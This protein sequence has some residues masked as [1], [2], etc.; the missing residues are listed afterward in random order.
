MPDGVEYDLA[1]GLIPIIRS[2]GVPQIQSGQTSATF[3]AKDENDANRILGILRA[4]GIVP[5]VTGARRV[6]T[7]VPTG[8]LEFSIPGEAAWRSLGKTAI[9][10]ACVLFGNETVRLHVDKTVRQSVFSGNPPIDQFAGWDF[11]NPWPQKY[12]FRPHKGCIF[13]AATLSGFE[14]SVF[15]CDVA[16]NWVAYVSIFEHMRFSIWL[17]TAT[18]LPSKGIGGNPRSGGKSRLTVTANPP[19]S[20]L[21]RTP[22]SYK[23]EKGDNFDGMGRAMTAIGKCWEAESRASYFKEYKEGLENDLAVAPDDTSQERAILKWAQKLA[24]LEGGK[25]WEEELDPTDWP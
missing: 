21:R 13:S 9:V 16:G 3:T 20:Y 22:N 25:R 1:P 6:E 12:K 18:G 17:G 14:H 19:K 10:A 15:I 2:G 23:D 7:K 24:A 8:E 5:K 4:K 11:V